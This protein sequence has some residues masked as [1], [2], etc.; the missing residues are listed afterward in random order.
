MLSVQM[1]FKNR[2]SARGV[3]ELSGSYYLFYSIKCYDHSNENKEEAITSVC[4]S[5]AL[6][7]MCLN[8]PGA[9]GI[10]DLQKLEH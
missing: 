1:Y 10:L 7:Q 3:R 4:F 2:L 6:K 8:K 9:V 5:S